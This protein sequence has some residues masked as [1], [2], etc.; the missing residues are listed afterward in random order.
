MTAKPGPQKPIVV[1][2]AWQLTRELPE[3]PGGFPYVSAVSF[4]IV[5]QHY[6]G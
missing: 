1:V 2:T 4:R 6:R 3:K 5:H